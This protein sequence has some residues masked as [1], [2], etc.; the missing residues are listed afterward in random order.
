M[1]VCIY[2][3][4]CIYKY[5]YI[6]IYATPPRPAALQVQMLIA[7]SRKM[8]LTTVEAACSEQTN[9]RAPCYKHKTKGRY[10]S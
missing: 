1:Y 6:D 7:V 3:C 4:V 10:V 9:N 5:I 2:I 8:R